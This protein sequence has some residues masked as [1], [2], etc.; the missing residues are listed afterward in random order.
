M[1]A[2]DRE[3][4]ILDEDLDAGRISNAEHTDEMRELDRGARA[5]AEEQAEDAYRDALGEWA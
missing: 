4:D 1:S 2:Y 5:W 3:V